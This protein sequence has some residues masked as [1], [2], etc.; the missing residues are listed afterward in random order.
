M[1]ASLAMFLLG[2]IAI[3]F[4]LKIRS[5]PTP[6]LFPVVL[7][8]CVVGAFA[9]NNNLFDVKVM[10]FLGIIGF[11]MNRFGFPPAPL[12]IGFVLGPIF[13]AGVRRSLLMS[14]GSM[15]IFFTRPI[16]AIFIALAF[17]SLVLI[18]RGR[19]NKHRD[20]FFEET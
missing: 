10:F 8:F 14:G 4:G 19:R 20:E 6:V 5:I 7:V 1:I 15:A 3:H 16:S 18:V 13:E 11:L 9:V 12:V 2:K 17:V